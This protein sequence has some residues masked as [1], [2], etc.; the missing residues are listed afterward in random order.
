MTFRHFT[1]MLIQ[2]DTVANHIGDD[3]G[4]A[5]VQ[6]HCYRPSGDV[7]IREDTISPY[8]H[9]GGDWQIDSNCPTGG[10]K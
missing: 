2:A 1:E 5:T 6:F 7:S 9:S 8:S 4:L 10:D 3:P